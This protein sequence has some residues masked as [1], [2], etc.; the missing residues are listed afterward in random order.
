MLKVKCLCSNGSARSILALYRLYAKFVLQ[1]A[2][3][4]TLKARRW[5]KVVAEVHE[6]LWRHRLQ[7][8]EL[9]DQQLQAAASFM[10]WS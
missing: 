4:Q 1:Q 6:V 3:L 8:D 7:D 2:E 5:F 10:P 9:V